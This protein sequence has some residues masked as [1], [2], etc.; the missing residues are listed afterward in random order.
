MTIVEPGRTAAEL[1]G[2]MLGR[3]RYRYSSEA[4]LQTGLA[5]ALGAIGI[6]FTR[7]FRLGPRDRIDFLLGIALPAIGIEVKIDHPL[8]AFTR[9]LH[10]YAAYNL[11]A[12]IV[13]VGRM[14]LADLPSDISGMPI[15][16]VN[17][18]ESG[19]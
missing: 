9:Q 5:Q 19:L 1:V 17:L 13:V 3:R 11:T 16:V 18:A 8:A 15:V 12:L 7:E 6:G 2:R 4:D 10:R 14:R